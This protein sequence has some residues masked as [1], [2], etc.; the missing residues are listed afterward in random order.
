MWLVKLQ[1]T[2][3]KVGSAP[4]A[5]YSP[6]Q[7]ATMVSG[8]EFTAFGRRG[9]FDCYLFI[10]RTNAEFFKKRVEDPKSRKSI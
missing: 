6:T 10:H 8:G 9:E 4:P 2:N 5:E 7:A 1:W 3:V